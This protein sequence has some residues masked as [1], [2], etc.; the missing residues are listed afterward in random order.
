MMIPISGFRIMSYLNMNVYPVSSVHFSM[1]ICTG[2]GSMIVL[3]IMLEVGLSYSTSFL[4]M[5]VY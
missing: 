2:L 4:R 3:G 1:R 5:Y